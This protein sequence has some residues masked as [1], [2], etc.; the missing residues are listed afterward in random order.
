MKNLFIKIFKR[1]KRLHCLRFMFPRKYALQDTFLKDKLRQIIAEHGITT[2][3]ETGTFEG[4]STVEFA[5]L[6]PK[7]Y[8]I[9]L[10]D[11][12]FKETSVRLKKHNVSNVTMVKANSPDGLRQIMPELDVEKTLFFLDAH[13]NT[14]W[15]ILDEISTIEKNKGIILI[16]DFKVPNNSELGYDSYKNQPLDYDFVKEALDSWSPTHRIEYNSQAF[17]EKRGVAFVY[18]N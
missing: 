7:V 6:V 18:S 13:W 9:E 16:H 2:I 10:S 17:Y 8:G 3:V 5:E 12:F 15:P 4:K 11:K 1:I 14:Y